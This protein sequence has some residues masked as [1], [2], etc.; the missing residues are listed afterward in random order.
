MVITA[1]ADGCCKIFD[2]NTLKLLK[3]LSFRRSLEEKS[4][5]SMRGMR[6]DSASGFLYTIQAPLR[7]V[8]YLTKW[9]LKN[10]FSPVSSILASE[11]ICTAIDLNPSYGIIA[12]SDCQG[13][14]VYVSV[15]GMMKKLKEE[16]VSEI[17]IKSIAF[18]GENLVSG[19]ADNSLKLNYIYKKSLISFTSFLQIIVLILFVFYLFQKYQGINKQN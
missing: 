18:K 10:N 19:A 15:D 1:G 7:G 8:T 4:N 17:T 16:D 9:D 13:K 3:K 6:Y 11:T 14:V 12:L 2:V 5:Y